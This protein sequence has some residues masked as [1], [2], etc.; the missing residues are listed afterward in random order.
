MKKL[1]KIIYSVFVAFIVL[2]AILLIVSTFPIPGNYKVLTVISG[3]MEPTI[4]TGSVVVVKPADD[5]NVGDVVTFGKVGKNN[6]PVTHRIVSA[7]TSANGA[8]LYTTKGDANNNND[9]NS[10]SKNQIVGKVL[11]SVPYMGYAVDFAK[12]PI[13]FALIIIVPAVAIIGDE[14]IKIVREIKNKKINQ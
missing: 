2:V 7:T 11:F 9:E 8:E 6:N 12:K 14:I 5:Y 3:S 1:F 13:G 10:L 4:K